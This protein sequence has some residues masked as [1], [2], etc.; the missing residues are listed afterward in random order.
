METNAN[1]KLNTEELREISQITSW[2]ESI[3]K[4]LP[5]KYQTELMFSLEFGAYDELYQIAEEGFEEYL[6]CQVSDFMGI[7]ADE[8]RKY[9]KD[10]TGQLSAAYEF[11]HDLPDSSEERLRQELMRIIADYKEGGNSN[12]A[13]FHNDGV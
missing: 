13:G 6:L 8:L 5:E 12:D 10:C 2:D 4:E 1:V 3:L 11:S 7:P 9:G